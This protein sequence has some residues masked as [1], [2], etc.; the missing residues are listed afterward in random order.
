MNRGPLR[1]ARTPSLREPRTRVV[2]VRRFGGPD[3]L[4]VVDVPLPTARRSQAACPHARL[5]VRRR[6]DPYPLRSRR[7]GSMMVI[8]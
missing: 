6:A 7:S 4:E 1:D 5:E 2:Q 3:G 8:I